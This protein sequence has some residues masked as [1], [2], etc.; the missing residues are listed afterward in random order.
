MAQALGYAI[1][2]A[3]FI[4]VVKLTKEGVDESSENKI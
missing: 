2:F 4:L 3:F 1:C